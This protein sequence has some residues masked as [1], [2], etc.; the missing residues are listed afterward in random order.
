MASSG[1][2]PH[3]L[4][5]GFVPRKNDLELETR[6]LI[7]EFRQGERIRSCWKCLP[8]TEKNELRKA[9]L[10]FFNESL[11]EGIYHDDLR[12]LRNTLWDRKDRTLTVLDFE[13]VGV[14]WE[15]PF[16]EENI[17]DKATEEVDLI[18]AAA[19]SLE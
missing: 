6:V 5:D 7:M 13:L 8:D 16:T 9:L 4:F 17:T 15:G 3:I 12:H 19:D 11:R 2:T 18:V 14:K 1:F 10:R